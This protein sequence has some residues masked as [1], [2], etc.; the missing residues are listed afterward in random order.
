MGLLEAFAPEEVDQR[1][2]TGSALDNL[3]VDELEALVRQNI[4]NRLYQAQSL[5]KES[6]TARSVQSLPDQLEKLREQIEGLQRE[7]VQLRS[8][9]TQATA[10]RRYC[11]A[12]SN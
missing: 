2:K 9:I 12:W 4:G 7:N 11:L 5:L 6:Q 10:S 8:K 3:P 1:L